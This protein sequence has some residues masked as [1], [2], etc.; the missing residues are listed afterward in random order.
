M[1]KRVRNRRRRATRKRRLM[2]RRKHFKKTSYDGVCYFVTHTEDYI[3]ADLTPSN[4]TFIVGGGQA[5]TSVTGSSLYIDDVAEFQ[6]VI[7]RWKMWRLKGLKIKVY[8]RHNSQTNSTSNGTFDVTIASSPTGAWSGGST[9]DTVLQY[10][11]DYK[12]YSVNQNRP[13]KRYYNL[14]KFYKKAGEEWI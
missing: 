11:L 8:P 10:A 9:S 5:G 1:V 12:T 3:V 2:R 6:S 14:G 7:Q 13:I 4:A